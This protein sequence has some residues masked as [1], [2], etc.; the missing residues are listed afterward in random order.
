MKGPCIVNRLQAEELWL[1]SEQKQQNFH[2]SKCSDRARG[3]QPTVQRARGAV[4]FAYKC[5]DVKLS[6]RLNLVLRLSM[7]GTT[8]PLPHKSL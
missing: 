6:T 2:F 7:S 8:D 4:S 1:E 5:R 3:P